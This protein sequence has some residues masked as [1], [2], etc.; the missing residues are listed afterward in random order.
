M[1][2]IVM[3]EQ[4]HYWGMGKTVLGQGSKL[5]KNI[6]GVIEVRDCG[7]CVGSVLF[8]RAVLTV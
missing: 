4:E 7:R 5:P 2:M 8:A 6:A 3:C 1:I